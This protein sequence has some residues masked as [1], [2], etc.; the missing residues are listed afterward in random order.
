MK[1]PGRPP[2][3]RPP[4]HHHT[5]P[6]NATTVPPS[7]SSAQAS[8][9]HEW[10]RYAIQ[11]FYPNDWAVWTARLYY[12][13]YHLATVRDAATG[14]LRVWLCGPDCLEIAYLGGCPGWVVAANKPRGGLS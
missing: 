3:K 14:E 9:L 10:A 11:D 12:R 4:P 7:T 6:T 8:N 5:M 2:D 13:F 1:R